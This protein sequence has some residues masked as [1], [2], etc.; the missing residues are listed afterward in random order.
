MTGQPPGPPL[1]GAGAERA[2]GPAGLPASA[3]AALSAR[4]LL[5]APMR[6]GIREAVST[7]SGDTADRYRGCLLGGAIGDALGR[8]AEGRSPHEVRRRFGELRDFLPWHGWES[9]PKGT[10]TDDTQLTMCVTETLLASDG[11]FDAEDFARRLVEWLPVGRG[12]GRTCVAAVEALMAGRPWWES[13]MASA[14]NG[15]AMRAAPIG[16]RHPDDLDALRRDAALSAVVTHADPM[17][18]ASSVAMAAAAAWCVRQASGSLE[19]AAFVAALAGALDGV[20]D[21]GHPERRP[22]AAPEPVRLVDRIAELPRLLDLEPDAAFARLHNGAF[23]LESLPAALWCFLRYAEDPEAAIVTAAGGG[24]DA[25]TVAAM[26]GALAGAYHGESALPL[27]WTDDLEFADELRALA[28]GL[29]AAARPAR[30]AV[31]RSAPQASGQEADSLRRFRGCLLGG[32]V[33]DA[34]GAPLEFLSSGEIRQRF[35]P[36]GA[37]GYV[38]AYGRRGAITDDTQMTLFT[39]EGLIRAANRSADHGICNPTGVIARAYQRWLAT[40]EPGAVPW[41]PEFPAG[42]SGWLAEQPFLHHRRAPGAT[43]VSSLLSGRM[44][45]SDRPTNDSKGCGGVMRVAPIGLVAEDPF[46]LAVAAAALTHGH[47][48]GYLA[49]GALALVIAELSHGASVPE[50]VEAARDRVARHHDGGEV[51]GALATAIEAAQRGP[52]P[53]V[54]TSL[55]EGW[56]AE[57]A[58]AISVYAA[59]V[60]TDFPAGVLLAVNHGG[61]SDSTGAITGNIL[62]TALGVDAIPTTLLVDLEGRDVIDWVA[63]DLHGTTIGADPDWERYPPF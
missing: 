12:R 51:E 63:R 61:D 7:P 9:G 31:G 17:A 4:G 57:E 10:V 23:V 25:D 45:S 53:D 11:P 41:D 30:T 34:L 36:A 8:P 54:L 39:A 48:T 43:C 55:G 59:L 14:G 32:A 26:A 44:G 40:Q 27:R 56:V 42:P 37:G 46:G 16:L 22:G 15:A 2:P 6:P 29:Q 21:P 20:H 58:L 62:G 19:P 13:G 18:V 60:A 47:P 5:P 3:E 28:E 49:A 1:A 38:P 50:A 35:G 24:R 33:G 52:D